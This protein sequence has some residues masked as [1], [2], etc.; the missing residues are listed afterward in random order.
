MRDEPIPEDTMP[1]GAS[2]D[3]LASDDPMPDGTL[4]IDCDQCAIRGDGCADCVVS[5][6][7]G[8]PPA[9]EW[10]DTERRAVDALAD[11]GM[12]PKLRLVPTAPNER[13]KPQRQRRAG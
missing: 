10:D 13:G 9:V 4:I 7:L 1:T 5:V 3:E 11:A 6:L 8:A 12:V 2:R